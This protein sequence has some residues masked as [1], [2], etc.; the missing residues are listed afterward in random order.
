MLRLHPV[1]R[2]T[3][4]AKIC[5]PFVGLWVVMATAALL[6]G[7]ADEPNAVFE[8]TIQFNSTPSKAKV[9]IDGTEIG[10]TPIPAVLA[11]ECETHVVISKPGFIPIDIYEHIRDGHLAPNPVNAKLRSELLPNARGADPQAE[12]ARCLENLKR[13]VAIGTIAPEDEAYVENQIR[14]FYNPPAPA[15]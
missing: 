15:K 9:T 6:A 7:C 12:L 2:V 14:E 3:P 1:R 8:E 13:Y 4:L 11:K 10:Q 5:R